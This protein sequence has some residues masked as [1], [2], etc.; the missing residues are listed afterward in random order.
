[1]TT[2]SPAAGLL[3]AAALH[4]A[5]HA[6]GQTQPAAFTTVYNFAG[7]AD[8]GNPAGLVIGSG[9]VLYGITVSGGKYHAGTV[10]SL[11]PPETAAGAWTQAVLA[12]AGHS[13]W[14][15][16]NLAIGSNGVVYITESP[17]DGGVGG[18]PCDY[19]HDGY[20]S[21]PDCGDIYSLTPPQAPGAPWTSSEVYVWPGTSYP[22]EGPAPNSGLAIGP[23][24]IL[25]GTQAPNANGTE[26]FVFS[27][28][29][30]ATP[31]TW[32]LTDIYSFALP[33]IFGE[34]GVVLGGGGS[35]AP[36]LYLVAYGGS[37]GAN[38]FPPY[39]TAPYQILSMSPTGPGGAWAATVLYTPSCANCETI[40]GPLAV[41]PGGLLYAVGS[42]SSYATA[43]LEV[44]SLTP[45]SAP[46]AAWTKSTL[47]NFP[48]S[49]AEL[50]DAGLAI[51]SDGT[52]Y[53]AAASPCPTESGLE[54]N[55]FVFSL[56][57]PVSGGA[58]TETTLHNF[59]SGP[60]GG[61]PISQLAIGSDGMLYGVTWSGGSAG[62]GTVFAIEVP[63]P[64]PSINPGGLVSAASY[65]A[66]VAP[67]SIASVFG[68]FF[69]PPLSATQSPLPDSLSG[70]SLQFGSNTPAPL[71]FVSGGQVN[72]QVPCEL[73]GQSQAILAATLN[74][75][76]GSAQTV[77][78][79]TFSPA[80]FTTNAQG[81]GQGAILDQFNHLVDASNPAMTGSTVLQIFCTG[82]GPVT[83]Q[84]QT[85]S[86]AP[87]SPL[88][89]TTVTPTVTIGGVAA[90][91]SFSGLAPGYVGLYQVNAQVPAGLA[92]NTAAPVVISMQGTASNT[93]TIAVQ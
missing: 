18:G 16:T 60:Y 84:P 42:T 12:N 74:G 35:G 68:S 4:I 32:S 57:P 59:P 70:L 46:G 17:E 38:G 48:F 82:L 15:A 88:S 49:Q 89:Y 23:G 76:A 91:V 10:F 13:A 79:A 87:L 62:Y 80:I 24:G 63:P 39:V 14:S 77:N 9:G 33:Q 36:V 52:I 55:G 53:G 41:G 45:P 40:G 22:A 21:V 58:W 86:P 1:M 65:A 67:G 28:T 66:P 26:S 71:F 61:P 54:C 83:N 81:S 25:Y 43:A 85:G 72:L 73:A 8:G 7:G 37:T 11:T 51:G 20:T 27:L 92:P 6:A 19:A 50:F 2:R 3:L 30:P 29:Q 31:G 44:F 47:Y 64:Q 34:S 75:Q 90:D 69:V 78:L 93:V 5:P 56:T